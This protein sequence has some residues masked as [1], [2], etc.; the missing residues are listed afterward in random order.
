MGNRGSGE[1]LQEI[2]PS[3]EG[4]SLEHVTAGNPELMLDSDAA[5]TPYCVGGVVVFVV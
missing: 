2:S 4:L 5:R 1:L 3:R